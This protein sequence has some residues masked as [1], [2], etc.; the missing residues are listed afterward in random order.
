MMKPWLALALMAPV[1]AA[2]AEDSARRNVLF[3]MSDDM[4]PDLGCYGRRVVQSPHLKGLATAWSRP[5]YSVAG[6]RRN[7]GVAVRTERYRYA[8][9]RPA[10]GSTRFTLIAKRSN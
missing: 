9:W 10:L 6:N 5:A 2:Q 1:N 4:R 3:L 8:E 7:L